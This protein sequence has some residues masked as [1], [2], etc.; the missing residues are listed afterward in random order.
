M[1]GL[2]DVALDDHVVITE[3]PQRF[4]FGLGQHPIEIGSS[5]HDPDALAPAAGRGLEED[6]IPDP[7][8]CRLEIC[9]IL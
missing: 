8:G 6:R 2:L 5:M 3:R 7:F 4:A 1:T 9:S